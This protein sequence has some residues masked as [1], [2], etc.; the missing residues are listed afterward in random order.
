[1]SKQ[2]YSTLIT[3][4][5]VEGMAE[6]YDAATDEF[7]TISEAELRVF[8]QLVHM[9]FNDITKVIN[10]E[11]VDYEPYGET[12]TLADMMKDF[13]AG[14]MKIHTTGNDSKVWGKFHNL[15]FRAVHDF[16]HLLHNIDFNH[17]EELVAFE[18]QFAYSLQERYTRQFPHLN[19]DTYKRI[20]RSEIV[21]QSAYKEAF[22]EFHIHQ[23][24]I[25]SD[26]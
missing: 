13:R 26:L 12:P 6:K 18:R 10:V 5:T 17:E 22:G 3:P 4:H 16:I 20:L 21:Y 9:Q 11:F 25:L 15:E 7:D 23:K 14:V 8:R 1:M 2:L 24:V 19:W